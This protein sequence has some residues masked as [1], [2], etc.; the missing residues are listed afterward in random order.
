MNNVLGANDQVVMEKYII[1][2]MGHLLASGV[3]INKFA[4]ILGS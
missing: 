3:A 1:E 2:D 4:Q